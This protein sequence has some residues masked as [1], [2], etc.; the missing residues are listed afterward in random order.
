M[1]HINWDILGISDV[2]RSAEKIE[3]HDEY[4]LYY[5]NEQPGIY[6]VGFLVMKYLKNNIIEFKGVS[7][8]IAILNITLPGYKNPTSIAQIYA[9]TETAK[10]ETK[11]EFYKSLNEIME[12]LYKTIIVMGDF[13]SQIG[14]R[15]KN[16]DKI[17]GPYTIGKRNDNGQRLINYA[18]ENNLTVMNSFYKRNLLRK[19]TW[20]SPDGITRNEIDFITTN[21]PKLFLNVE[22][23]NRFNFNTDHRL[24]RGHLHMFQP[25]NQR[26]FIKN[27]KLPIILPVP[28][29]ILKSLEINLRPIKELKTTQEKYNT[30]ENVLKEINKQLERENTPKD[31]LGP[32]ARELIRKRSL[33]FSNRKNNK[34]EITK[35]SKNINLEIRN[36]KQK[37]RTETLQLHIDKSG[38][39]KKAWKELQEYTTWINNVTH[40]KTKKHKSERSD[41]L[42]TATDF[43]RELYDDQSITPTLSKE[44][45]KNSE[46]QVPSILI[47]E[48]NNATKS[49]KKNKAP[50]EDNISNELLVGMYHAI[51]NTLTDLFNDILTTEHI[52]Q[53][54]TTSTIILIHKKGRTDDISNYRPISLMSNI[55]KLF[56]KIV[57]ERLTRTLDENQP[58]EQAGFRSGFSTLDHIHTIKQIIQ[59]CNEYNINY[60]LS[61]IDYNKAFD[62]LKHQK[63]WEALALQGVHNKYIRLLKNI[64]ENMKARVRTERLGEHFHIKKGV[65]QGDPL[66]PKLFSAT[67]EHVFRQLEWDD[68]GININGVLLNHLRFADDLIL[69]SENPETL[70][71]MIEQL[72]R[73]SE[74]VGLSLNTS[75][76]KLMTNYKKVPI[77]PYNTA[78][79]EYV[80]EYTYLG[81]IIS[82]KDLTA[83]EI[84]NRINIGWKR[85]W[86]LKDVMKNSEIP[87]KAKKKIFNTCILPSMTYG[88]QTW[89]LTN[90]NIKSLEICQHRMERSM[91]NMKLKDKIRLTKIRK[92]TKI[93]DIKYRIQQLKWKWA[94]HLIRDK[95]EKWAKGVT[96]WC[97]RYKKRNRGR[98]QRRWEDDIKKV[99]GTTWMR[100]TQDRLLW[101]TLGEAYAVQQDDQETGVE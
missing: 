26:K 38:G 3:E 72:V 33:L 64:Y 41:I 78:K 60:Y 24:L 93:I 8:R 65:R 58:K 47:D 22:V 19:C 100:K 42:Q 23:L 35:I 30:L 70:Q 75:K 95:T 2:R 51:S 91:L 101:R 31:R 39:L 62:S 57:L 97:P 77:K 25:K 71:K 32:I 89:G 46:E 5:K 92:Q 37:L 79:L 1:N 34:Q 98:Q 13:N 56:S 52:P 29:Y 61:F 80:N 18:A 88:C 43:Y 36:H 49:L 83:K 86:A 99:A 17:I 69:I 67:L 73:E 16:E 20:Q 96:E 74:K 94:G 84:S 11:N 66:S 76:T 55:Y 85:Y 68:Y 28:N 45:E 54:W 21:K 44:E 10:K 4:I 27:R 81:Q 15:R 90:K 87:V 53:Q 9:P 14:Q 50:G 82:H 48:V 6:G 40:H 59:K 12:N 63:I 7:N